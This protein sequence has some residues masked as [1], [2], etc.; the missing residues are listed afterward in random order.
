MDS[1]PYN[2]MFNEINELEKAKR[3]EERK[4]EEERTKHH[5]KQE[6]LKK[7]TNWKIF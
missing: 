1:A 6:D 2:A 4:V 3:E 5:R 7:G